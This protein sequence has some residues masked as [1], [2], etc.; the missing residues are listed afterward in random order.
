MVSIQIWPIV[1]CALL[2]SFTASLL[3]MLGYQSG[4]KPDDTS[5]FSTTSYFTRSLRQYE[6]WPWMG[7]LSSADHSLGSTMRLPPKIK[8]GIEIIGFIGGALIAITL[9]TNFPV[10]IA[11]TLLFSIALAASIV[12]WCFLVL[13]DELH[14]LMVADVLA[15]MIAGRW[16]L[17][18]S[19]ASALLL[20]GLGFFLVF[21]YGKLRKLDLLGFGDVK[22]M[23]ISGL[24]LSPT[25]IPIYLILA[26]LCGIAINLL[27]RCSKKGKAS[28]FGPALLISLLICVLFHNLSLL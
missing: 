22:L 17:G 24:W 4:S 7:W 20:L 3:L 8:A 16:P 12:D 15:L 25:Q 9:S 10:T 27:W 18:A 26:G 21:V 28:P 23:A 19:L 1:S 14:I 11:V 5:L 6:N 13:P 2:G